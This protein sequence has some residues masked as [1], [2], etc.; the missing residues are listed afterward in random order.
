M[1]AN[2]IGRYQ[3]DESVAVAL[4]DSFPYLATSKKEYEFPVLSHT[5]VIAPFQLTIIYRNLTVKPRKS[6]IHWI[7]E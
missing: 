7:I 1:L 6:N 4:G 5:R 2:F 3:K